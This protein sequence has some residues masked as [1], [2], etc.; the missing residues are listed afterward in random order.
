[1]H[2]GIGQ[3][4]AERRLGIGG[5]VLLERPHVV[6]TRAHEGLHGDDAHVLG[7]GFLEDPR[8]IGLA[9]DEVE[10]A[11][12]TF[13]E[14]RVHAE[15]VRHQQ[16]IH[17]VPVQRVIQALDEP[18]GVAGHAR[19]ADLAL[20]L[21]LLHE[22][23]P[24][25]ILEPADVVDRMREVHVH[26]VGLKPLQA[27]FQGA[28]HRRPALARTGV[29]LGGDEHLVALAPERVADGDLGIAA[30]IALRGVEVVDAAVQRVQHQ[31]FLAGVEAA[32]AEGDVG[33]LESGAAQGDV[34]LHLGPGCGARRPGRVPGERQQ[35]RGYSCQSTPAEKLAPAQ[36]LTFVGLLHGG[37]S[38][39][40]PIPSK[41]SCTIRYGK[42]RPET[43][44][45]VQRA[46]LEFTSTCPHPEH[47]R[48]RIRRHPRRRPPAS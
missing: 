30:T 10:A 29:G 16:D 44:P 17:H 46:F 25:G 12:E 39:L 3:H 38:S 14:L 22:G 40:A 48:W 6:Q 13:V 31:V 42:S 11:R 33:D 43:T 4:P 35:P 1:M 36:L 45:N 2:V 47:A 20:F 32:G 5:A 28:H 19:E 24:L 26:V 37:S 8:E 34:A 41:D 7:L 23:V 9:R 21:R 15:I 18:P 27:R